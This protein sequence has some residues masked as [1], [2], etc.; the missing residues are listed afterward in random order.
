MRN[1]AVSI[2]SMAELNFPHP[3]RVHVDLLKAIFNEVETIS[4]ENEKEMPTVVGMD[5]SRKAWGIQAT[6]MKKTFFF[7]TD[8]SVFEPLHLSRWEDLE[9]VSVHTSYCF[10]LPDMIRILDSLPKQEVILSTEQDELLAFSSRGFQRLTS[11]K[12]RPKN[13]EDFLLSSQREFTVYDFL[14]GKEVPYNPH[15][16]INLDKSHPIVETAN[17]VGLKNYMTGVIIDDRI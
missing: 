12:M 14:K 7:A 6:N 9:H 11:R 10:P 4:T 1:N 15:H 5:W 13:I 8:P 3:L 17:R 16:Q 2:V